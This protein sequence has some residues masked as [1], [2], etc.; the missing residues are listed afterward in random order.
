MPQ[1]SRA[2]F[3]R[4]MGC[5]RVAFLEDKASLVCCSVRITSGDT[6]L[7]LFGLAKIIEHYNECVDLFKTLTALSFIFNRAMQPTYRNRHGFRT[8]RWGTTFCL[9][10]HAKSNSTTKSWTHAHWGLILIYFR[11]VTWLR[12]EK[13]YTF[14]CLCVMVFCMVC[15]SCSVQV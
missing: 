15:H 2:Q 3:F 1:E 4:N 14:F 12:L 8:Q 13:K 10:L 5:G 11:G 7:V 6:M 9:A